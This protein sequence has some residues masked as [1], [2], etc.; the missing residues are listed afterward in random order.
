M[1]EVK[2]NSLTVTVQLKN[3]LLQIIYSASLT[4]E[5]RNVGE[6]KIGMFI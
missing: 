3:L 2:L 6:K 5:K 4:K 1:Q